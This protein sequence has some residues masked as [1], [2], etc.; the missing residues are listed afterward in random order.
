[1]PDPLTV[2]SRPPIAEPIKQAIADAFKAVPEGKRGALLAIVDE[3]GARLHL[4]SRVGKRWKVG[5]A[6]GKPFNGTVY[7]AAWVEATW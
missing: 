7:G 1:M 6:V 3:H 2:G 5:A 4:A